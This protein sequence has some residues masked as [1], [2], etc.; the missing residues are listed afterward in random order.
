[1]T[2]KLLLAKSLRIVWEHDDVIQKNVN[3]FG[4]FWKSEI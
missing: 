4:T 1:M 3:H 2:T